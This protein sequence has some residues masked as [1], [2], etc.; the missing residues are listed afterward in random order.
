M[1]HSDAIDIDAP[2]EAA[3][4]ALSDLADMGRRSPENTGG[5]WLGGATGPGPGVRFR[6]TNAH[7]DDEWAT[8]ATITDFVPPRL[9]AFDVTYGKLKVSRWV[10]EIESTPTGCRVSEHWTDRRGALLKRHAEKND[11]YDRVEYTRESIRT[12]LERLKAELE[13]TA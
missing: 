4:A 5:V 12:T 7:G 1:K 6:G 8:V 11:D 3:F 2:P 13:S 9:F 10:F